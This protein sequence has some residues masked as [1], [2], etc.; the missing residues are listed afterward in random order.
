[1]ND[2]TSKDG[3]F[4]ASYRNRGPVPYNSIFL[5]YGKLTDFLEARIFSIFL[6]TDGQTY[7]FTIKSIHCK[8]AMFFTLKVPG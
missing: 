2:V 6:V 4:K 3:K 5:I 1:M 8:S 7:T